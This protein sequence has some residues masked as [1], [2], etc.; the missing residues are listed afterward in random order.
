[1]VYYLRRR[2]IVVVVENNITI[3]EKDRKNKYR[4]LKKYRN[5]EYKIV[6]K[7]INDEEKAFIKAFNEKDLRK[8]YEFIYDYMCKYLDE[9][10]CI[11]CDFK[12]NK[13]GEK[14]NTDSNTGCCHH[15][16]SLYYVSI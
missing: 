16:Q 11:L 6:S 10:I 13:C 15:F 9:N 7:A 5:K 2:I 12:N 14:R 1:M 8:R 4:R 3:E